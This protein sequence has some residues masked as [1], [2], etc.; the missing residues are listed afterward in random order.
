MSNKEVVPSIES[1][2]HAVDEV[3]MGLNE[4]GSQL[5]KEGNYDQARAL[6]AKVESI[7]GFRG[8]VLC[9]EDDW[10][11]LDVPI[12]KKRTHPSKKKAASGPS[13]PLPKGLKT[14]YEDFRYPI[15][16]AV[17]RLGG[18]GNIREVLRIVE[19]SL[20]GQLN[21]YDYQAL[22]SDPNSVRWK[23]TASWERYNMVQEGLLAAD[24]QRGV[25]EI[26]DA[27]RDTLKNAKES[28]DPQRKLF[29][30]KSTS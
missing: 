16:E 9:L 8:K 26:T 14:S 4:N 22:S 24:S 18:S 27:G 6:L 12:I 20:S 1:L 2:L 15:L 10:K 11:A 19:E 25:W 28:I 23:N 17:D 5:F 29:S 3:I 21:K 7:S 13:K 30:G